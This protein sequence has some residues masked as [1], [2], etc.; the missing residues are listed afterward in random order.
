VRSAYQI[1][2]TMHQADTPTY[3]LGSIVATAVC[4]L[5][6]A[7]GLAIGIASREDPADRVF[8]YGC[9]ILYLAGCLFLNF[10]CFNWGVWQLRKQVLNATTV[11]ASMSGQ[12]VGLAPQSGMNALSSLSQLQ[13]VG[14]ALAAV[15]VVVQTYVGIHIMH[16]SE[17]ERREMYAPNPHHY[18]FR[19]GEVFSLLIIGAQWLMLYHAWIPFPKTNGVRTYNQDVPSEYSPV[20]SGGYA[21]R[22]Y[23]G[24]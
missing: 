5:L 18:S 2:Q 14:S 6:V 21:G 3:L 15:A 13:L 20:L 4:T 17:V 7:N 19:V 24:T 16:I 23:D 10:V 22:G 1:S 12:G 9:W 11:L 8:L